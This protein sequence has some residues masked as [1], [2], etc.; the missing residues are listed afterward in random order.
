M[1]HE[2]TRLQ[3]YTRYLQCDRCGRTGERDG[4]DCEFHEFTS[5]SYRAGYGSIFGDGNTVEA[6]LCQH[7]VKGVLG[8]W[9]RISDPDC[10]LHTPQKSSDEDTDHH[11]PEGGL[12]EH[13]M[14]SI[15]KPLPHLDL[16][17]GAVGVIIYVL[18][19]GEAYEVEFLNRDGSTI[20]VETLEA[21]W[22]QPCKA[23]HETQAEFVGRGKRAIEKSVAAGDS[24]PAEEVIAKLEAKVAAAKDRRQTRPAKD[25]KS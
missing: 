18:R 4:L 19:G 13:T 20:G 21:C 10:I 24:V 22:V 7:C 15:R 14:V 17:L 11:Q 1:K 16:P 5:I 8:P 2:D 12:R 3:T 25:S 23:P 6:D 9:L